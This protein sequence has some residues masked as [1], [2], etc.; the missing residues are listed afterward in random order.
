MNVITRFLEHYSFRF[1]K[2]Y[3][4]HLERFIAVRLNIKNGSVAQ[5]KDWAFLNYI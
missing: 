4:K 5:S 2:G 3:P 1:P